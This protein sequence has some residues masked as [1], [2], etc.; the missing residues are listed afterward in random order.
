M[1]GVQSIASTAFY[2]Y[3]NSAPTETIELDRL[4]V[5]LGYFIRRSETLYYYR[6]NCLQIVENFEDNPSHYREFDYGTE[7]ERLK[8][9]NGNI[10]S[11]SADIR[12]TQNKI[13]ELTNTR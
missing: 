12:I 13:D 1:Q 3:V 6:A 8:L 10:H 2:N 7:V 9:F 11:N 4:K 5:Q